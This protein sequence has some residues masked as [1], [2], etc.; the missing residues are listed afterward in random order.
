[1]KKSAR[2]EERKSKVR[3][4]TTR[5]NVIAVEVALA[6]EVGLGLLSSV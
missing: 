3:R 1:M 6:P 5:Q 2:G 4:P